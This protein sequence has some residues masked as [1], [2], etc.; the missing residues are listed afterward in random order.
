MLPQELVGLFAGGG[1]LGDQAV[2]L[3]QMRQGFD[4]AS[5]GINDEREHDR[6]PAQRSGARLPAPGRL[7]AME[8]FTILTADISHSDCSP[9]GAWVALPSEF[10]A[11]R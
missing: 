2:G 11:G 8:T 6:Q 4:Q 5:M 9:P 10:H 1:S 7:I 3:K